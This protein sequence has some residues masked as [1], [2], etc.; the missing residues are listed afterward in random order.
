[1]MLRRKSARRFATCSRSPWVATAVMS[2][3]E[4]IEIVTEVAHGL[5]SAQ[6]DPFDDELPGG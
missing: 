6:S 1:M 2:L 5:P 4:I 3:Q